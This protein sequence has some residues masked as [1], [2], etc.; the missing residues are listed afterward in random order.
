MFRKL[1]WIANILFLKRGGRYMGEYYFSIFVVGLKYFKT[2]KGNC[3]MS[4]ILLISCVTLKNLCKL[5]LLLYILKIVYLSFLPQR[6]FELLWG[7]N[8][9][10]LWTPLFNCSTVKHDVERLWRLSS[11]KLTKLLTKGVLPSNGD[12]YFT[13][14]LNW[15][16]LC[17][18]LWSIECDKSDTAS[19]RI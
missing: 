8:S 17:D 19:S 16:Q 15:G 12:V 10:C 1:Q 6:N 5:S 2:K 9:K 13:T 7:S 4:A 11:H 18:L 14:A 3:R